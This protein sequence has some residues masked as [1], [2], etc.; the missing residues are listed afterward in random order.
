M[1]IFKVVGLLACTISLLYAC[2][3]GEKK[4]MATIEAK[5][6]STVS[7]TVTFIEKNGIVKMKATLSGLSEG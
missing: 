5:S 7:G 2:N 4:A 1:K 3:T 6:G